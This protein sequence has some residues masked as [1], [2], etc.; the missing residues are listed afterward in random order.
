MNKNWRYPL[1][2]LA[3][4]RKNGRLWVNKHIP[5]SLT[6]G[7]KRINPRAKLRKHERAEHTRMKKGVPYREAHQIALKDEH[8][9]MTQHQIFVYEGH[10]GAV[11]RWHPERRK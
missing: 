2:T 1:S 4:F 9:G 6:I 11:A 5:E 7:K 10:N 3:G 8:R